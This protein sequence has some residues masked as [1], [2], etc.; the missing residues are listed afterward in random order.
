M[1]SSPQVDEIV[2]ATRTR[3]EAVLV[4][5]PLANPIVPN[6]KCGS[7]T[8]FGC[9][10]AFVSGV[11]LVLLVEALVIMFL[12][13]RS[14][15]KKNP[16]PIIPH[17][18][19]VNVEIP[20]N[21]LLFSLQGG[22]W[23]AAL[24][25]GDVKKMY[26]KREKAL[27]EKAAKDQKND[28]ENGNKESKSKKD[29]LKDYIHVAPVWRYARLQGR[30]L[31]LS[32]KGVKESILLE[33]CEV[34]AVSGS[35]QPGRKWAKKYPVKL[36]NS[37]RHV[38]GG[39]HDCLLYLETGWEKEAWCEVL[40]ASAN[41]ENDTDDWYYKLKKEYQ[42][43]LLR[44]ENQFPFLKGLPQVSLP[45]TAEEKGKIPKAEMAAITKK[46]LL[47][48]KLTRR[49][50]KGNKGKSSAEGEDSKRASSD[51]EDGSSK[52]G[53]IAN[54]VVD[55]TLGRTGSLE[56]FSVR[57]TMGP[58]D[59]AR[60][61][62]Y[63]DLAAAT[64]DASSLPQNES[65]E[66][67]LLCV[68]M[69]FSR[70]FFDL[71]HSPAVVARIRAIVQ[72][73][74]AKVPTP[75]YI[76][77]IN[78][79]HLDLGNSPPLAQNFQ[80]LP[81]ESDGGWGLEADVEYYGG[82]ILTIETRI[83]VRDSNTRE[84][85]VVQ[86]LEQTLAGSATED[87]LS[88]SLENLKTDFHIAVDES[89]ST[90][91]QR[92]G[93]GTSTSSRPADARGSEEGS[94]K[95]WVQSSITNVKAMMSRVAEQVS[96]VPLALT[97]RVVQLKGTLQVRIKPPPSDRVWFSFTEMPALELLP[98][99]CIGDHK[100][101]SGPLGAFIVNQIKILLRDSMV[102]PQCE[103]ISYSWMISEAGNWVSRDV[104]PLAF[105]PDKEQSD[106]SNQKERRESLLRR[107]ASVDSTRLDAS[108]VGPSN[109][110]GKSKI[111]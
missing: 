27:K 111:L 77:K 12:V 63:S 54:S 19:S 42:E 58:D 34:V 100:I 32:C 109:L 67:S 79:A 89:S 60:T 102:A 104:V 20:E 81:V 99:P 88:K 85:V 91:D 70:I 35:A 41:W 37:S 6:G 8:M 40:R 47:W 71:Y 36:H 95:G 86:G 31:H 66:R 2:C 105:V 1:L 9:S 10:S 5:N 15:E 39:S 87:L 30:I 50:L 78:C 96:Q 23:I 98:E 72:R 61:A 17:T 57:D 28:Q 69:L 16:R 59:T 97:I 103:D 110:P 22:V 65:L 55:A 94:R 73:Q 21:S 3:I 14:L 80:L 74:L 38:Y 108:G 51:T 84:K 53:S 52:N 45:R 64:A 75:S 107:E 83:D 44:V 49:S 43:Y 7:F 29:A 46:R 90:A 26:T 82:A 68:N 25:V 101:N 93:G 62:S 18:S 13:M 106:Q 92:N 76:G 48:K 24:P 4:L 11:L 56:D 33:G